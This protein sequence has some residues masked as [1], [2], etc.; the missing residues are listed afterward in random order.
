MRENGNTFLQ[1]ISSLDRAKFNQIN[2]TYGGD[3]YTKTFDSWQHLKCM[4]YGVLT[5]QDSLRTL[6]MNFNELTHSPGRNEVKR[7]TLSDANARRPTTV[8]TEFFYHLLATKI[9]K[10]DTKREMQDV[11]KLMDSTPIM[12]LG[13]GHD[14]VEE[15]QRIRGLKLHVLYD[16]AEQVPTYF[17]FSSAKKNDIREAQ[18][19]SFDPGCIYV[20]DRAYYDYQWWSQLDHQGSYF[21]TRTK[22]TIKY[23]WQEK[24]SEPEGNIASDSLVKL[25]SAKGVKN[26]AGKLRLVKAKVEIRNKLKTISIITNCLHKTS[27]EIVALYRQR[28]QIELFFKWLKQHIKIKKFYGENENAI[29]LQV[30]IAMIA[31]LL[32]HQLKRRLPTKI[33]MHQLITWVKYNVHLNIYKSYLLKPPLILKYQGG[34]T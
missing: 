5:S 32:L 7:S 6:I 21:V 13:R 10:K 30:T 1:L 34:S 20:F 28:W 15:T 25:S 31:Y 17:S 18:E 14:W 23:Q 29:K 19:W 26:Y 3:H 12:L 8:F 33:S 16:A 9:L 11:V 27:E 24:H 22:N 2:E 4:L